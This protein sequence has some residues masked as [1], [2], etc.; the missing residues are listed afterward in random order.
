MGRKGVY[1]KAPCFFAHHGVCTVP[2]LPSAEPNKRRATSTASSVNA[3]SALIASGDSTATVCNLGK[4]SSQDTLQ[5]LSRGRGR[6][7]RLGGRGR[8]ADQ[9]ET[10]NPSLLCVEVTNLLAR[11]L[12]TCAVRSVIQGPPIIMMISSSTDDGSGVSWTHRHE[13]DHSTRSENILT[14]TS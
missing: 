13:E 2:F 5:T 14:E 12:W 9:A 6:W 4:P 8:G 7:R 11:S 10:L 1:M 3:D